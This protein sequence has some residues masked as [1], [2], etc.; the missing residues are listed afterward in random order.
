MSYD[1]E[2]AEER[3]Q[4]ELERLES[5]DISVPDL[6]RQM[7]F[8]N[9]SWKNCRYVRGAHL[10]A[11]I[12]N[13][14]RLVKDATLSKDDY[15]RLLRCC[16]ILERE[17]SQ[18]V[19]DVFPGYKIHFQGSKLHAIFHKPYNDDG[20]IAE[21]AVLSAITLM[22]FVERVFNQAFEDYKDFHMGIGIDLGNAVVTCI[23]A[24][25][26]REL[27]S[28]GRPANIAAKI[29]GS[30]R[31]IVITSALYGDLPDFLKNL[32]SPAG[33]KLG[34]NLYKLERQGWKNLFAEV[35]ENYPIGWDE[36]ASRKRVDQDI[37]ARPLR[38]INTSEANVRIDPSSLTLKNSKRATAASIFIDVDA[39]TKYVAAAKDENERK[40][41]VRVFHLLR[42]EF[43]DVAVSDY[44]G[45]RIQY[46]GDRMQ[47]IFH[48]P[49][50]KQDEI[51]R[52]VVETA[53]ACQA[54]MEEVINESIAEKYGALHIAI[55]IEIGQLVVSRLGKKGDRDTICLGES[56]Y[57]AE[58]IQNRADGKETRISENVFGHIEDE[59]LKELFEESANGSSEYTTTKTINSLWAARRRQ[60]YENSEDSVITETGRITSAVNVK[61]EEVSRSIPNTRPWA[62]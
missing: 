5:E 19:E 39:F 41:R 48:I 51:C 10:Y 8:T 36:D 55:G 47:A 3:V 50:N 56:V 44:G 21:N 13:V 52:E 54:S 14:G 25:G 45:V 57:Q 27:I 20:G 4:A 49:K 32:F 9:L 53:L 6:S 43:R 2:K 18:I 59:G 29:Q 60:D 17:Q 62:Q 28:L 61:E 1:Y 31:E 7:D 58:S 33:K 46:Q 40:D 38:E 12:T 23:G 22:T 42:R 15:G 30:A 37:A 11:D 35:K 16:E 26:D 34:T 24:R